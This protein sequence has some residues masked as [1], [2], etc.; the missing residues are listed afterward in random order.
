MSY[1]PDEDGECNTNYDR[2][3]SFFGLTKNQFVFVIIL[4][5]VFFAVFL[6]S[7]SFAFLI[8]LFIMHI[9]IVFVKKSFHLHSIGVELTLFSAVISGALFGWIAGLFT[10]LVFIITEYAVRRTFS[11]FVMITLPLYA[12]VGALAAVLTPGSIVWGGI[13]IAVLYAALVFPLSLALGA[14]KHRM[15]IFCLSN[16]AWNAFLF[17]KFAPMFVNSGA[18]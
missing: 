12:G 18:L 13:L 16:I 2:K 6:L 8:A 11:H 15:A 17:I 4:A 3:N 5:F 10:G 7:K 9:V 1:L 14:K